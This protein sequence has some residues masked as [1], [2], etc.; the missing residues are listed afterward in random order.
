VTEVAQ[1]IDSVAIPGFLLYPLKYRELR[2]NHKSY[3]DQTKDKG[4]YCANYVKRNEGHRRQ[5]RLRNDK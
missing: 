3:D 1:E 4:Y 2:S 5:W